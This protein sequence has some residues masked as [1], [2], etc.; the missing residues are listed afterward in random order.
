[1]YSI[2]A[3]S[4]DRFR[5]GKVS[6]PSFYFKRDIHLIP[7]LSETESG[8]SE[9]D[10]RFDILD[11]ALLHTRDMKLQSEIINFAYLSFSI[12]VQKTNNSDT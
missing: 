3:R 1:M 6:L 5:A 12:F 2:A 10:M 4:S 8:L 11:L 9:S 7:L